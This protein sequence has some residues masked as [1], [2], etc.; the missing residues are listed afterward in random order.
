M[1]TW[2]VVVL[3]IA[4]SLAASALLL[5]LWVRRAA[6]RQNEA[7]IPTSGRGLLIGSWAARSCCWSMIEDSCS[8][9]PSAISRSLVSTTLRNGIR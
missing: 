7:G 8:F 1:D 6:R 3:A 4:G 2:L 9:G 5:A